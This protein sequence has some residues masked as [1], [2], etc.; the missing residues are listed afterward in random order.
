MIPNSVIIKTKMF[1]KDFNMEYFALQ[2]GKEKILCSW[3]PDQPLYEKTKVHYVG[4]ANG[5]GGYRKMI[6]EGWS[7][8]RFQL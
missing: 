1:G 4:V 6:D 5:L 3:F 2:K 8:K 7:D